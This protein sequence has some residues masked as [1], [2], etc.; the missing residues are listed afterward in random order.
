MEPIDVR[1]PPQANE[2][3][4]WPPFLEWILGAWIVV[5][6]FLW[7]HSSLQRI[8]TVTCGVLAM[9]IGAAA[10]RFPKARYLNIA[11]GTWLFFSTY[12]LPT[13]VLR[14]SWNELFAGILLIGVSVLPN[15]PLLPWHGF[16]RRTR[17][18]EVTR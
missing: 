4:G 9:I 8:N 10:S 5:S 17:A 6:A 3:G 14:T 12:L 18:V 7:P 2:V 1:Q 15:R 11:V 13:S 16:R